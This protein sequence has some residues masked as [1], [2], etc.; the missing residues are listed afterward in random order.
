LRVPRD[1]WQWESQLFC[2]QR[3]D[4]CAAIAKSG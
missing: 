3:R 2:E 1:A 4:E